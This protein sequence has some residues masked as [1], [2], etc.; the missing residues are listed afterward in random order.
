MYEVEIALLRGDVAGR[1]GQ[2][3]LT[4]VEQLQH[5]F[6]G[7]E[8]ES[9]S[10]ILDVWTLLK[11]D[12]KAKKADPREPLERLYDMVTEAALFPHLNE[13]QLNHRLIAW[14]AG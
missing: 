10:Y 6:K 9:R 11:N 7:K 1:F 8:I 14:L 4:E 12:A 3:F 5:F 2:E 13:E